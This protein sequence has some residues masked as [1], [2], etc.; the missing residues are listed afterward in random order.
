MPRINV[1]P[2]ARR[3][4][5]KPAHLKS[6]TGIAANPGALSGFYHVPE[7]LTKGAPLVV[8]LH[9]CTQNAAAYD[10][11]AGWSALADRYGFAVLLP[12]QRPGNNANRCFNWF[13]PGDVAREHGEAASIAA[14]VSAMI[15]RHGLDPARVFVTGLSA[16]GAMA[17][18]MCATY[19]EMFAAGAVVAGLPYGSAFDMGSAFAAMANPPERDGPRLANRVRAATDHDGRWPRMSIWHGDS[20]RTVALANA[21]ALAAQWA[22]LHGASEAAGGDAMKRVW[23]GT[24]DAAAVELWTVPGMG[25]GVPLDTAEGGQAGPF[26]L[27]VGISSSA[28]IAEFWGIA[29]VPAGTDAVS[30]RAENTRGRAAVEPRPARVLEGEVMGPEAA[31]EALIDLSWQR[32]VPAEVN[33]VI[34]NALRAAGLMRH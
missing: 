16:G 31:L 29:A 11:G 33:K 5:P 22:A 32:H 3:P 10:L 19:P 30:R 21:E 8:A 12:E 2:A 28:A 7:T 18:A 4:L 1:R 6:L 27:D 17:A 26:M 9:G 14:M 15:A 20:D 13:E 23:R 24:D 34:N 25:H